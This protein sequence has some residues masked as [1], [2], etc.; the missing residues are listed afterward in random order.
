M[1]NWDTTKSG[2]LQIYILNR[3]IKIECKAFSSNGPISFGSNEYWDWIYFVN[4]CDYKNK[5][6]QVYELKMSSASNFWL[7][8]KVNKNE[9]FNNQKT[10]K[11]R[12]R[13]TF[14]KLLNQIGNN[15]KLIF[16][17]TINRL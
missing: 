6:F 7:D 16:D 8:I 11:R 9:T 13:I 5:K 10:Q 15:I 2:D 4:A 1:P 12:P 17:N 3:T 14:A